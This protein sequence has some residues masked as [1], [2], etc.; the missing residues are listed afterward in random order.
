MH[1]AENTEVHAFTDEVADIAAA[2]PSLQSYVW[3]REASSVTARSAQV[4]HGLMTLKDLPEPL[5]V[6]N[7]HCYLCGPVAFM[8]LT[9]RQLL[10]LGIPESQIH[11][12]C[13]GPHKVI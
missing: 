10:E 12:E 7:L 3:Y 13:F 4:F 11:Y 5:P 6:A 8:Q 2:L 9:A 1:A